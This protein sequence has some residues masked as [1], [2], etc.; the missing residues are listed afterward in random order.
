MC[1]NSMEVTILNAWLT[2]ILEIL[3]HTPANRIRSQEYSKT[4]DILLD[5]QDGIDFKVLGI[6]KKN[7]P[8]RT[9]VP[10]PDSIPSHLRRGSGKPGAEAAEPTRSLDGNLAEASD[11]EGDSGLD[12]SQS[13]VSGSRKSRSRSLGPG[14]GLSSDHG[15]GGSSL[16]PGP[17]SASAG[18]GSLVTEPGEVRGPEEPLAEDAADSSHSDPPP[19]DVTI[20]PSKKKG[21]SSKSLPSERQGREVHR[22]VM[23]KEKRRKRRG[24]LNPKSSLQNL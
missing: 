5:I 2:S 24:C 20:K 19:A 8:P 4:R 9:S 15:G 7:K 1:V 16:E 21:G 23:Q 6:N 12:S 11:G 18:L 22:Q 17:S 13:P 10:S 3:K 14:A